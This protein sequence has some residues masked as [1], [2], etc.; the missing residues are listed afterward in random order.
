MRKINLMSFILSILSCLIVFSVGFSTWYEIDPS[1][2]EAKKEASGAYEAYAVEES[3]QGGMSIDITSVSLF[4][5]SGL[6]FKNIVRDGTTLTKFENSDTGTIE[7]TYVVTGS[8]IPSDGKFK[9]TAAL[10]YTGASKTTL[11]TDAFAVSDNSYAVKITE[12]VITDDSV[13][14]DITAKEDN[15]TIDDSTDKITFSHNFTATKNTDG[16]FDDYTFTVVY[17]FTIPPSTDTEP[18][19]FRNSFGKHIIGPDG[20]NTTPTKFVAT[21]TAT[22][23]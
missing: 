10:G 19:N 4:A 8:T 16:T 12:G 7:V 13:F 22:Q 18:L 17:T 20:N 1:A 15:L 21:A 6:S 23:G 2:I 14:T 9:V 5:F 3:T 11:F